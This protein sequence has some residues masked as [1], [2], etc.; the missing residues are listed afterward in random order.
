MKKLILWQG[1]KMGVLNDIGG[2]EDAT[3]VL[4]EL[5]VSWASGIA[6]YGLGED[7]SDTVVVAERTYDAISQELMLYGFDLVEQA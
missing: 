4:A 5:S 6:H 7:G 3:P 1:S 2:I